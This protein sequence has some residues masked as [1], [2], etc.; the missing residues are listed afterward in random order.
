MTVWNALPSWTCSVTRCVQKIRTPVHELRD[1]CTACLENTTFDGEFIAPFQQ[2]T[3]LKTTRTTSNMLWLARWNTRAQRT[4]GV[5]K[6]QFCPESRRRG[7][8]RGAEAPASKYRTNPTRPSVSTAQQYNHKIDSI[9]CTSDRT[10]RIRTEHRKSSV[11][12]DSNRTA[13]TH[14]RTQWLNALPPRQR[15]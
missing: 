14:G 6:Y 4:G 3:L 5:L 12:R 1:N 15:P 7:P 8:L 2:W 10:L 9:A 11:C 13:A